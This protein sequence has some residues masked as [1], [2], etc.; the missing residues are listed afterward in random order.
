MA[1]NKS[2]KQA[3][4]RRSQSNVAAS[5]T[6]S[7][8][9][10]KSATPKSQSVKPALHAY[11]VSGVSNNL[12]GAKPKLEQVREFS[13]SW[14][15]LRRSLQLLW[16]YK[17][18]FIRLLLL[19]VV[20]SLVFVQSVAGTLNVGGLQSLLEQ[21]KD[22]VSDALLTSQWLLTGGG[23]TQNTLASSYAVILIVVMSM[24]IIWALRQAASGERFRMRDA[25]YRG[26]YPLVPAVLVALWGLV[27]LLPMY[28]GFSI[29][30]LAVNFGFADSPFAKA[31]WGVPVFGLSVLSLWLVVPVV[32][33]LYIVTVPDVEPRE[34][35][36][37][38]R[39]LVRYTRWLVLRKMLYLTAALL[40]FGVVCMIVCVLF[41]H[42]FAPWFLFLYGAVALLIIHA[43]LYGLYREL[44]A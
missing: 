42:L 8:Y 4:K 40:G 20:L 7:Q 19:Y 15:L 44:L 41:F 28:L 34:A 6:E 23:A 3:A 39:D 37:A 13:T 31:L 9:K 5:T 26:M 2:K 16:A 21:G 30:N 18:V 14:Q 25:F 22:R 27:M 35:L 36:Q 38:G 1:K 10:N 29:F 24:A 17:K 11:P 12:R 43:Y 32:I 33:A